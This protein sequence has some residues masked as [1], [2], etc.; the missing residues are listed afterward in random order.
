MIFYCP[1]WAYPCIY[2]F[3]SIGAQLLLCYRLQLWLCCSTS[4]NPLTG[5]INSSSAALALDCCPSNPLLSRMSAATFDRHLVRRRPSLT[6]SHSHLVL[7]SLIGHSHPLT[8]TSHLTQPGFWGPDRVTEKVLMWPQ[9]GTPVY[10]DDGPPFY[11]LMASPVWSCV[12]W[13]VN[14]EF[15]D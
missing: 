1:Y 3:F 4:S 6:F 13:C 7:V 5:A 12:I 8:D 9:N 2:I 15:S 10:P 11:A 14:C